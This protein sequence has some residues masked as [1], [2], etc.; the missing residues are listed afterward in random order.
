MDEKRAQIKLPA[1]QA[2]KIGYIYIYKHSKVSKTVKLL[3][4]SITKLILQAKA[5][6]LKNE[7]ER[8][9]YVSGQVGALRVIFAQKREAA[10]VPPSPSEKPTVPVDILSNRYLK[11]NLRIDHKKVGHVSVDIMDII[12]HF[13]LRCRDCYFRWIPGPN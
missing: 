5:F 2:Q 11:N 1:T 8:P 12:R 7:R 3:S 10:I 4:V 6:I 13:C 9:H